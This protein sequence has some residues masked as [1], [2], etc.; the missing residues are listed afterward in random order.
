MSLSTAN[1]I[2]PYEIIA[3]IGAGGMGEVYR[4]R[5]TRLN[6][7]VAIKILPQSFA[8]DPER[9][10]RFQLEAESTG[11]LNH[12]NVL[13]IYDVGTYEGTPYLVSELLEGESLRERLNRGKLS[14]S[15]ALDYACQIAAGLA[16]A[17]VK[18]ITHR[19]VKPGN[20]YIAKDG[21]V[22]LLDFG[23]AKLISV[24]S[25]D[26]SETVTATSEGQVVG[27]AAYM[28]P[29]QVRG[30]P[31][32]Q[33]SDIFG[34]GCVLYEMLAGK[35][36][37]QGSTSADL[38]SAILRDEPD[39]EAISSPGLQRVVA[40]CLEKSP[41]QRFQSA[42][43]IAFDLDSISHQESGSA[44]GALGGLRIVPRRRREKVVPWSIALIASLAC[45]GFAYLAF[46]PTP[47][48]SFH[49]L[50][51]RRG[52]I[53][54]ARF[55][56]DGNGVVYSAKW[57]DEPSEIFNAR[58]DTPGSRALG[59]PG[60][61]LRSISSGGELALA[62]NWRVV[63][64]GYAVAGLLALAPFSGGSPRLIED[65]IDFAEW[66]PDGKELAVVRESA[67][68]TQLEFPEG[69]ILY[70]TAGYISEPRISPDGS[71]IAF[72]DHPLADDDG[73]A[74]GLVDRSGHKK[75][76]TEKYVAAQGLAWSPNGSEIWFTAAKAG[77][78]FDLHAVSLRGR[79]RILLSTPASIVLQDVS[80]SG[81]AL[82]TNEEERIKLLF[83]GAADHGER[84]LSW[85]DWS[86]LS[87]LSP[88]GRYVA[89]SESGEGAGAVGLAYLR[90]T[91]GAPAV[92]LGDGS[93]PI[94]SQ[95]GRSVAVIDGD[96]S[97]IT[98]YP[99]GP[100]QAKRLA[101]PG[102]TLVLAGLMPDGKRIWF[103][104]SER[105]HGRRYYIADLENA[106]ARPVTA[107]GVRSLPPG[108]VLNGKYL[109]GTTSGK[110]CLYPVKGGDPEIPPGI[111][112]GERVAGWSSD[113]SALLVYSRN[114]FPY[115]VYRLD[116]NG[117]RDLL[118]G[119]TPTD[120]A[121]LAGGGT[122]R[123]TPDGKS[124]AYS[125]SQ[126]LSELQLVEGLK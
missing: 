99:V 29:E 4:A 75:T 119:V 85:L 108:L 66:S 114:E 94:L 67:L 100:G 87:S 121:G 69:N 95:D 37:F 55:T 53:H 122:I 80:R 35:R 118:L 3:L 14:V 36:P 73:G 13:A 48:K 126:G 115:K 44:S 64:N 12:P 125:V 123:V 40:H 20:I 96:S 112:E 74:V 45:I 61:I 103:N 23:L 102:Y 101:L 15:R 111:R 47:L 43:D 59:F 28:S 49:R 98:I 82:I 54:A 39:W 34:F 5:D 31:I 106:K 32:D 63:T 2:G 21:R 104:G 7:D 90:E 91:S 24:K 97:G 77:V 81:R 68:G 93:D 78:R 1:R 38:M 41:E 88:D 18:G 50:T 56:P 113:G 26:N 46:R 65:N 62:Q 57:E 105:S 92:L 52:I 76:L 70:K 117:K 84:E 17:H 86:L 19:D 79:E 6:R 22:K 120:R 109:V 107:E 89:F 83:H 124:Y 116:P 42:Q 27:T 58:L 25:L 51:F 110:L 16:A 60:S 30:L 10:R 72:L 33:R 71:R 9:L 8:T 11:A